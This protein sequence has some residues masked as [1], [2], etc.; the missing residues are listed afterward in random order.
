M[1][2]ESLLEL[3]RRV[4]RARV[5][6][7]DERKELL[8]DHAEEVLQA[9]LDNEALSSEEMVVLAQRRDLSQ[10]LLRRIAT[11]Q[12]AQESYQ[13]KRAL[14]FNPKTPASI[15]LRLL[16]QIFI[17]DQMSLILV[18]G[19]P[20]EVKSAAEEAIYRKLPQLSLG[21]R[22]TLARRTN[23]ERILSYL[24]DDTNREVVGAVLTN[25]FL[26]ESALCAALRRAQVKAHTVELVAANAKWSCR[27]DVR[28]ALLRTRHLTAG[29][30]LQFLKVMTRPELRDL[31]QDPNVSA[32]IRSY[33]RGLLSSAR[34]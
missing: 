19:I 1:P 7:E 10:E 29:M 34:S 8:H 33:I 6:T 2:E 28:Y 32:Q 11:D 4:L 24:L 16:G 5:A 30:A 23:S 27:K 20:Q 21:E 12:R 31:S 15:S 9:L 3:H 18:V 22:L 26:R 25:P 14:V 13:L 17:F